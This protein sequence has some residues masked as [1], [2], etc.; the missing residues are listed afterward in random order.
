MVRIELR[1]PPSPV[2]FTDWDGM[3]RVIFNRKR[4]TLR[5]TMTTKATLKPLASN[6][7]TYRA[8]NRAVAGDSI[9]VGGGRAKSK[10]SR[11]GV[12]LLP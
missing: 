11:Q 4:K 10:R 12:L 3:I 2:N 9:S 1:N 8:I 7:N 5:A 6:V